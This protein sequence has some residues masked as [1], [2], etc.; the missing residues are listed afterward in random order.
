MPSSA[1]LPPPEFVFRVGGTTE[2]AYAE[3]DAVGRAQKQAVLEL[4]PA[5]WSFE[6]KRAL[7]FGCGTGRLLRQF[8]PE[9]QSAEFVGCDVDP[10]MIAWVE[11][12]LCPPIAAAVA[13][14]EEPPLPFPD[15]HFD[16]A[17]AVSV[18]THITVHWAEWILELHRVLKPGGILVVTVLG[19]AMSKELTP[20]PWDEDATGMNC[21]GFGPQV[22]R[23]AHVLHSEWWIRTHWGRAFEI[24]DFRPDGF[25]TESGQ[26][27]GTVVMKAK[28]ASL[29]A[30]EMEAD[31]PGEERYA[32]ARRQSLLL[33]EEDARMLRERDLQIATGYQQ[34]LSWRL[35][36]P[37][38]SVGDR[39]RRARSGSR[40]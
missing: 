5:G 39:V 15:D 12:N 26:G 36:A 3:F 1:P 22:W 30:E 16:F 34:S 37:M 4:L 33:L 28:P 18:F 38:R 9:A 17:I 14:E 27:H 6:G 8:L 29:T 24:L 40:R 19:E 2:D 35:T 23:F 13:T 11:R 7:D 20:V 10:E 21:F 32:K 25:G 31:E